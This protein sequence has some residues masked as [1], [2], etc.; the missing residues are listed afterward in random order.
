M[1][2]IELTDGHEMVA[3]TL[4]KKRAHS[5]SH[6]DYEA[7]AFGKGSLDVHLIGAKAEVA[8]A[9][10]YGIPA[11]TERRLEGDEH[12]FEIRYLGRRASLDVKATTYEPPWLQVRESKSESD[13]YLACFLDTAASSRVNLVGW[14]SRSDVLAGDYIESPA[15]GRH[16]NYRLKESDLDELPP[17]EVVENDRVA[18]KT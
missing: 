1:V 10:Y 5:F 3:R 17:P 8:V 13:Y 16:H 11:D 6:D 2:T 9:W 15:G 18:T 4:A 12:D 7:T 14:A